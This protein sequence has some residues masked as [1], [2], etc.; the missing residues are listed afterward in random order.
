MY[1]KWFALILKYEI[2][3]FVIINTPKYYSRWSLFCLVKACPVQCRRLTFQKKKVRQGPNLA[4]S[5]GIYYEA[6]LSRDTI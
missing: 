6:Q 2:R 5:D 1:F 4:W 3:E